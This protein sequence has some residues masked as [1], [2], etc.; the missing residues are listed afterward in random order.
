MTGASQVDTVFSAQH[1]GV[2]LRYAR[3]VN[4]ID[5]IE[6]YYRWTGVLGGGSFGEVHKAL[7][8]K[9]DV[10][11]AIKV[12]QKHKIDN[13]PN[14]EQMTQTLKDELVLL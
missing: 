4:R 5:D 9:S 10:E 8:L 7:N 3:G 1:Q 13:N 6:K 11:C 2:D 12:Y 14:S